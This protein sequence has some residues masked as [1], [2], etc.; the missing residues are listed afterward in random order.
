MK[1]GLANGSRGVITGFEEN[2]VVVNFEQENITYTITPIKKYKK[3][4][5][6][7]YSEKIPLTPAYALTIHKA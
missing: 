3:S 5:Y 1:S 6:E 2:G 7:L 4:I